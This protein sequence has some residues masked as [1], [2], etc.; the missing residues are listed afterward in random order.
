[1]A[2]KTVN[3]LPRQ[4][5]KEDL[6]Y[7][8][9][10]KYQRRLPTILT[11]EEVSRLIDSA[12]NLFHYA[13]LLTI[14]SAG[15]RR[16]ELCRL[17]VSNIDSGRMMIRIER[18]KGGVDR[19]APLNQKLLT[20]LREYWRWMAPKTYLFPGTLNGWRA[21]KP[22]TAKVVWEAVQQAARKAG[23]EKRVTPHMLRHASAYYTTFQSSFILKIIALDQA[24]STAVY[25]RD[26]RL[27]RV[28]GQLASAGPLA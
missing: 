20:T 4:D 11:P 21:D 22:I 1:V 2:S 17:K 24:Q 25:G 15:L 10:A 27:A 26:A 7:P 6:P 18:G 28:F 13:M 19:E 9:S 5:M 23:I 8:N 16:S 12:R 3:T 14:Y